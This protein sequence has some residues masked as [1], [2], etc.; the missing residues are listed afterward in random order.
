MNGDDSSDFTEDEEVAAAPPLVK[1][2]RFSTPPT[3]VEMSRDRGSNDAISSQDLNQSK[4][5]RDVKR[6]SFQPSLFD[7]QPAL[8]RPPSSKS[9]KSLNTRPRSSSQKHR[10]PRNQHMRS[11]G[12]AFE[13][14]VP[15][16]QLLDQDDS[17]LEN[18]LPVFH[19][20][21]VI[22]PDLA[23]FMSDE[24]SSEEETPS[25][26]AAL[27]SDVNEQ[28]VSGFQQGFFGA[29]RR[30][31]PQSS[32]KVSIEAPRSRRGSD[33]VS[34]SSSRAGKKRRQL[35]PRTVSVASFGHHRYSFHLAN[36]LRV[37]Y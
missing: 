17:A 33:T 27:A 24:G 10:R 26:A 12:L 30:G 31:R 22:D 37:L 15:F 14:G 16:Q 13:E 18:C 23:P 29:L 2:I 7:K 28:S 20:D 36:F 6:R 32:L 25:I 11:L 4:R 1:Q 9:L 8:A 19:T 5:Q 35:G 34:I 21:S 3:A